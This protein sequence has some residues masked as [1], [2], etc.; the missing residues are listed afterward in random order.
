MQKQV[1]R[2]SR[3]KLDRSRQR[4]FLPRNPLAPGSQR[5]SHLQVLL[6]LGQVFLRKSFKLR[7][8]TGV[9]L[10]LEAR[11]SRLLI[12]IYFCRKFVP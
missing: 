3:A 11:A 8:L 10:F 9:R 4:P 12:A 2:S 5:L 6:Q 7:V 1:W